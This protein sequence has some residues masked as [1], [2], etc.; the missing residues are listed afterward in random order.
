MDVLVAILGAGAGSRMGGKKL[1]RELTIAG[2]E[3][4]ALGSFAV[5]VAL[6]LNRRLLFVAPPEVP[7]FLSDYAGR[8]QVVVNPEA[9]GGMA[10]SLRLAAR[11]A[12]KVGAERLLIML[13][14][15]PFVH[16]SSLK[17][18]IAYT[19]TDTSAA[20]RYP[21]GRLGPPTCFGWKNYI[22]LT[23][24]SGDIGAQ[25]LINNQCDVHAID[26]GDKE[27]IDIDVEADLARGS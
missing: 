11:T 14:D 18:L 21:D 10:T 6:Q 20:C 7:A 3:P 12:Q 1:D 15:M 27:L 19:G 5:D 16:L 22:S 9:A 13:A 8:L 17:R 2:S 26:V 4:S 25:N 23:E 24:I